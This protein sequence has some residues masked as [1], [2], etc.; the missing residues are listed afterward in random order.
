MKMRIIS[1]IS[2]LCWAVVRWNDKLM[3]MMG[4]TT[5]DSFNDLDA[6]NDFGVDYNHV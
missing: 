2:F 1:E 4:I 5:E 3:C 6:N